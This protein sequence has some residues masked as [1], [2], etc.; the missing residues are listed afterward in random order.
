VSR[1]L[2]VVKAKFL[3]ELEQQEAEDEAPAEAAPILHMD[4]GV[5]RNRIQLAAVV[6][7]SFVSPIPQVPKV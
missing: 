6:P 1:I 4:M 3:Q 7:P 5:F 2:N